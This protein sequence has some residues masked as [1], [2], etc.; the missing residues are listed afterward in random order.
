VGEYREVGF[1]HELKAVYSAGQSAAFDGGDGQHDVHGRHGYSTGALDSAL[2]AAQH[3]DCGDQNEDQHEDYRCRWVGD[4]GIV[5]GFA[6]VSGSSP[7]HMENVA[8]VG[9][10]VFQHDAAQD[11]EKAQQ[12]ERNYGFKDPVDGEARIYLIIGLYGG[13]AGFTA[14]G[15]L[16]QHER[17]ADKDGHEY[18][19]QKEGETAVGSHFVWEGPDVAQADRGSDGSHHES[20][21]GTETAFTFI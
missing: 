4:K 14:Q 8:E 13:F 19:D 3:Y 16:S 17:I 7:R 9:H 11:T 12:Q 5:I 15:D 21:V 18:I 6:V 10:C 1:E 2:N 20:K